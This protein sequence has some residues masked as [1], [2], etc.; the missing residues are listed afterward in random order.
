MGRSLLATDQLYSYLLANQP[1]EHDELR[2]LR[3]FTA[4]LPNGR[5][6]I[7]P[8]QAPFLAF[9]VRLIGARRV[10]ELGTFTGYSTLAI[11]LALPADGQLVTCDISK[12]WPAI[13]RQY[14]ERANVNDKIAVRIGPACDTLDKLKA[15][16]ASKFDLVFI[17]A[18]KTDYDSYYESAFLLVR[19]GGLIVLDNALFGGR[20]ADRDSSEQTTRA[21]RA[22]NAKIANDARVD[23]VLLAVG[24]GMTLVHRRS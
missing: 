7:A 19:L 1:P 10:L 11:A 8:E 12:D 17:D 3:E 20:V 13:G 23:R 9:L 2:K 4:T 22:L 6:Q 24:D 14:W 16:P 5:F 15:D 21:I 18:N